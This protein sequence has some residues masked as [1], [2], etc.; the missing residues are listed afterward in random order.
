MKQLEK[1]EKNGNVFEVIKKTINRLE[2]ETFRMLDLKSGIC[3]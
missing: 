2:L 1:N 3:V